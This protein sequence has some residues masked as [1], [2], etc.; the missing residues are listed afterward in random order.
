MYEMK[1]VCESS[2]GINKQ[3]HQTGR[4]FLN[5]WRQPNFAPMKISCKTLTAFAWG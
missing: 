2:I 4:I 3:S 1:L 5:L